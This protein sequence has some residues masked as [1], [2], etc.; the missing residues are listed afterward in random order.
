MKQQK[1]GLNNLTRLMQGDDERPALHH[2]AIAHAVQ[3]L[4]QLSAYQRYKMLTE[5]GHFNGRYNFDGGQAY[6]NIESPSSSD[7]AK[8]R[9]LREEFLNRV[10]T[11]LGVRR[12]GHA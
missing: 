5:Y 4:L 2:V 3:K 6:V 9:A 1:P 8:T 10:A 12:K 7:P 11:E